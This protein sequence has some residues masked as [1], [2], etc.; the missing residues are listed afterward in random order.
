MLLA[1]RL[2]IS[3]ERAFDIFYTSETN[4]RLHDSTT[5]LYTFGDKYIVDDVVRELQK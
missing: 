5:L 3:P 4:K 2:R 1:K